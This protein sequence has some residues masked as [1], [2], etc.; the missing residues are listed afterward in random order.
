MQATTAKTVLLLLFIFLTN[1]TAA[2]AIARAA[3]EDGIEPWT[4]DDDRTARD[5]APDR[6][7]DT[8][9]ADPAADGVDEEGGE[10]A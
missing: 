2:H 5:L 10:P 3:D 1:P 8:G 7:G 9:S 6:N 4:S